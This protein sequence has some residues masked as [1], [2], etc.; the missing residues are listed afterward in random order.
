MKVKVGGGLVTYTTYSVLVAA[1]TTFRSWPVLAVAAG[2]LSG[3]FMNF[4]DSKRVVCT[5]S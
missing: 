4:A 3:M 1:S 2:S 5:Q